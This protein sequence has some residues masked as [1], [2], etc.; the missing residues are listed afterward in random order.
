VGYRPS[1]RQKR[2]PELMNAWKPGWTFYSVCYFE[3]TLFCF[4]PMLSV[5]NVEEH[6]EVELL[7]EGYRSD[8]LQMQL[9]L[10]SMEGQIDDTRE[11][12]NAHQVVLHTY[13]KK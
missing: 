11:L 8:L 4:F 10:R 13:L 7:L 3:E 5:R 1:S 2:L 6:E 9:E 12:I